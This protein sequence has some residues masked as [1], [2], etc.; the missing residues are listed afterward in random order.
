MGSII[1]RAKSESKELGSEAPR[2]LAFLEI[3]TCYFK[4]DVSVIYQIR[5][6][7]ASDFHKKACFKIMNSIWEARLC[8]Q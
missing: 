5:V 7:I 1:E 4:E 2:N 3:L 6:S 8:W